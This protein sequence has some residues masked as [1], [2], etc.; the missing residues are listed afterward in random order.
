MARGRRAARCTRPA[1]GRRAG[2]ARMVARLA[3]NRSAAAEPAPSPSAT[4][5][6][7]HT[8]STTGP[9]H[10]GNRL[11]LSPDAGELVEVV[12]QRRD[13]Q[14]LVHVLPDAVRRLDAE[15][16]ARDDTQGTQR[17]HRPR[18]RLA[19]R[20]PAERD[21]L[22]VGPDQLHRH[23]GGGQVPQPVAGPVGRGRAGAG[24]RDVGQRRQVVEREA[25]SLEHGPQVAVPDRAVDRDGPRPRG[26]C[27]ST[28]GSPA[29]ERWSPCVSAS[30]LNAWRD[31]ST[32][33]EVD[34]RTASWTAST[35]AGSRSRRAWYSR[36]PAQFLTLR[37]SLRPRPVR[38]SHDEC[39]PD[40]ATVVGAGRR[41][42]G[43]PAL[44]PG[45][46]T[47][48]GSATCAGIAARLDHLAWLGVDAI[49]ISPIF[50]SP[51]ADFG[52]DIA[53]YRDIDPVFGTLADFDRARRG[54]PRARDPGRC[55]TSSP[56]TPR[57]S[58]P[59]SSSPARAA[60][61]RGAT[62]TCGPI[63]RRAAARPTTG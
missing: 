12:A 27:R 60:P 42:P 62:G 14:V 59:G 57:T 21:E 36:L 18:E 37:D 38:L 48:T 6:L 24:H 1:A 63:P 25:G 15:R 30:P 53:D 26:R 29:S 56:T 40:G 41:L 61:T 34:D 55:S 43:L 58:I 19:V 3:P 16:Q 5:R 46:R 32:R 2:G 35:D 7:R 9:R 11:T 50:P 54:R 33:R 44:V 51:M 31:P 47:A 8:W 13:R 4:R 28:R 10:L 52:Y 39:R 45:L 17:D 22:A 23:D 49:W 20:R